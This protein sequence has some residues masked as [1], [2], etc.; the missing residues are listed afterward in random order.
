MQISSTYCKQIFHITTMETM[1]VTDLLKKLH[2]NLES[3]RAP[4]GQIQNYCN[5]VLGQKWWFLLH[6]G[7]EQVKQ[8]LSSQLYTFLYWLPQCLFYRV[9]WM[10]I[11]NKNFSLVFLRWISE[12]L[13]YDVYYKKNTKIGHVIYS[14]KIYES[15]TVENYPVDCGYDNDSMAAA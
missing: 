9:K 10:K 13:V 3:A 6:H 14:T 7:L 2:G 4:F 5:T 8:D 11:T 15:K 12:L 1:L